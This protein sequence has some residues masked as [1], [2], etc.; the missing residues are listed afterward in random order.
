MTTTV[1]PTATKNK[2]SLFFKPASGWWARAWMEFPDETGVPRRKR[3]VFK[4]DTFDRDLARRKLTKIMRAYHEGSLEREVRAPATTPATT[5]DYLRAWVDGRKAAGVVMAGDESNWLEKYALPTIGHLALVDV[6]PLHVR[7]ILADAVQH[8]L[9]RESVR[10]IRGAL[11]RAFG[12]AWKNEEIPENPVSRVD[13]PADAPVDDRDRV[14]LTDAELGAFLASGAVPLLFKMLA[15]LARV[16]GG[17]R[18]AEVNRMDWSLVNRDDYSKVSFFRAKAKRGRGGKLQELIVP[19][20]LRQHLRAWHESQDKPE[21]GVVFP[22]TRGATKGAARSKGTTYAKTLRKYL[23]LAGVVR[24][25]CAA[26]ADHERRWD[27]VKGEPR[28]CCPRAKNDPLFFDTTAS[29]RVDFHSFRRAFASALADAGVNEQTA[30][31]LASHADS[32]VH[33]LY[34]M[35]TTKMMVIPASAVPALPS[36]WIPDGSTSG[37]ALAK[38]VMISARP[39]R[40]ER[41]TDGL[42]G[43]CSIQLSYGRVPVAR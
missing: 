11:N 4:L 36:K 20:E 43:R 10:K 29:R 32:R 1:T 38:T 19:I 31:H 13:V 5:A 12:A 25:D 28:A 42:E 33:A 21:A 9:S 22:V 27:I 40:F 6:R 7:R 15:L 30:M 18:T 3:H 14:I 17:M 35:R 8:G 39:D 41:S 37:A 24:H 23:F 2:G 16:F 26:A 34:T